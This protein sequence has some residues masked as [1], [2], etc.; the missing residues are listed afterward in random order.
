M[1]TDK[2]IPR[3]LGA[4]GFVMQQARLS[5]EAGK[6]QKEATK[7][8]AMIEPAE[9]I[10]EALRGMGRAQVVTNKP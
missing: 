3:E 4:R 10:R 1:L 8:G 6:E 5:M 9:L 7:V 2:T